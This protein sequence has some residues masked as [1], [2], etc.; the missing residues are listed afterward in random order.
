MVTL[1]C[2]SCGNKK[3]VTE[4]PRDLRKVH[5]VGSECKACLAARARARRKGITCTRE[6]VSSNWECTECKTTKDLNT[7]NFYVVKGRL[8]KYDS[9]CRDC[10]NKYHTAL[11]KKEHDSD[12]QRVYRANQNI[13]EKT[14][15]RML[16]V[17]AIKY[18]GSVCTSCNLAYDGTNGMVFDFHHLDPSD[19]EHQIFKS[20]EKTLNAQKQELDKCVLLCANCHRVTHSEEY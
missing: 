1:E 3:E 5:G 11:R 9:I 10:R 13:R 18:K 8:T 17:E 16:K 20:K 7:L 14:K 2:G 6:W 4:F 19:K 15:H 12:K